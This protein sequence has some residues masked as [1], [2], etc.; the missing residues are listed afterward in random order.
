MDVINEASLKR[1]ILK[2]LVEDEEFRVSLLSA[3]DWE[4]IRWGIKELRER[5]EEHDRK[6]NEI[7][8]QIREI[9]RVQA[10]HTRILEEHTKRLEEH[11]RKFNEILAQIREIQR[12]QAEHTKRLEEHDRKFNEIIAEIR[13]IRRIQ[14]EQARILEEHG[15]LIEGLREEVADLRRRVEIT[16][17]S[18]GRRWGRD[19]EMTVLRIFRR[20][21]EERGVEPGRVERLRIQDRDGSITGYAGRRV[22]VDFC[23][24]DET[25]TLVEVKSHAN[26]DHVEWFHQVSLWVERAL[27]RRVDRLLVAVNVDD[28][29][30][31]R[32]R[33][34]GIDVVYGNVIPAPEGG[35]EPEREASAGGRREE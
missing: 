20:A 22:E 12:V 18:M 34:L 6:F 32:A 28:D 4:S 25:F 19:L 24:S 8:A 2:L 21:L 9:Q 3:L 16:I 29:A 17:G 35:E 23:V 10:E 15:R 27:G 26:L 11:D 14:A 31:D 30:L 1:A 7:L 13:E 33:E 5:A